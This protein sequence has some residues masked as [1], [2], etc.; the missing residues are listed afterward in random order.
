MCIKTTVNCKCEIRVVE[1]YLK[2]VHQL[3]NCGANNIWEYSLLD[4]A[5]NRQGRRKPN[6]RDPV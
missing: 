1:L 3:V 2:M 6:P 5:Q 4:P